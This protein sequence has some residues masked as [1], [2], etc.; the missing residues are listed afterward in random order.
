LS[1][2]DLRGARFDGVPVGNR[3]LG[4]WPANLECA[5]LAGARL[6]GVIFANANLE[7]ADLSNAVLKNADLRGTRLVDADL[8]GAD[9]TGARL[10]NA[11]TRG[12]IGLDDA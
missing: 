9:L 10:A 1:G 4:S 11:D 7:G 5:K 3:G 12:A 6:N 2:A 8:T